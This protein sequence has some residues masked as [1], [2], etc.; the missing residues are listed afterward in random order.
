MREREEEGGGEGGKKGGEG[1]GRRGRKGVGG[2]RKRMKIKIEVKTRW[3]NIKKLLA[4]KFFVF[5]FF[6]MKFTSLTHHERQEK[7]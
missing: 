7:R 5:I 3:I 4:H 6:L 1:K 2:I